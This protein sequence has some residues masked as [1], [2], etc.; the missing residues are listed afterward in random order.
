MRAAF[1]IL[2][3]TILS[4]CHPS[5]A[6]GLVELP[7]PQLEVSRR[8]TLPVTAPP[9][10]AVLRFTKAACARNLL[11]GIDQDG[12]AHCHYYDF[13]NDEQVDLATRKPVQGLSVG[14]G[15]NPE[16][17]TILQD[18]K[19]LR[20]YRSREQNGR[21][22]FTLTDRFR[23]VLG[24]PLGPI[25][26][27][28]FFTSYSIYGA[29]KNGRLTRLVKNASYP[30]NDDPYPFHFNGTDWNYNG[31]FD[32]Q[33]SFFAALQ[34]AKEIAATRDLICGSFRTAPATASGSAGAARRTRRS[35]FRLRRG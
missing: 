22:R 3:L 14:T 16:A 33:A 20:V 19:L 28:S 26:A 30:G 31:I 1:Y 17:I 27:D 24:T 34:G 18:G 6:T 9:A 8:T 5:P 11:C 23:D 35:T 21:S 2:S 4:S 15:L 13:E 32:R 12:R 7:A 10:D 29:F 25:E